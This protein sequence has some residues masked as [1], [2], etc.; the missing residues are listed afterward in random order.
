MAHKQI[1]GKILVKKKTHRAKKRVHEVREKLFPSKKKISLPKDNPISSTSPL[2][3]DLKGG[4]I[5]DAPILTSILAR[6]L[7][8]IDPSALLDYGDP[9]GLM[10][11]REEIAALHGTSSSHVLITSS[12]QQA[13]Y[14]ACEFAIGRKIHTPQ[15]LYLQQPAYFGIHRILNKFPET[16]IIPFS[17]TSDLNT[18]RSNSI[19]YLSSNFQNPTG[20]SLAD[21][22][23]K[24]LATK[25]I[26]HNTLIIEDNVYD[27]LYFTTAPTTIYDNAPSHVLYLGSF[28]KILAPGL[29][30]GYIIASPNII[31]SIRHSKTAI[32]L[33]TSLL[34]QKICLYALQ[35]KYL[36]HWREYLQ[37]KRNAVVRQIKLRL[38]PYSIT[39]SHP[40]GGIFLTLYL[41]SKI[42][43]GRLRSIA[44]EKYGLLVEDDSKYHY[45]GVSQNTIR[46]NFASHSTPILREAIQRL[47]KAIQTIIVEENGLD[48]KEEK[49][50]NN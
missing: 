44:Q 43:T 36:S 21:Q 49:P 41:P 22:K 30:V 48:K 15:T 19:I 12:A 37:N 35:S 3:I 46:I 47:S 10:A 38:S 8:T 40:K 29:R 26:L 6:S 14:L 2:P 16:K 39:H 45:S 28:S 9:Q 5:S 25:A 18:I 1:I 7:R 27:Q 4:C 42:P 32:D 17:T 13:L 20:V 11:L 33:S 50:C 23:K 31:S 24:A 34:S